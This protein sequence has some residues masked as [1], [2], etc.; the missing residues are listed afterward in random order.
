[1]STSP[2][3]FDLR[4]LLNGRPDTAV[5]RI[6]EHV[7]P[8]FARVLKIIG[9]DID[10]AH[11]Q[12]AYLYD[13]QGQRYIDCL[14]GY[15]VFNVGRNHPVIR[16]AIHQAM[17]MDL[18]NLVKMGAP[19][20]SGLLAE[21]LVKLA[22]GD[23]DTVF[24][25]NSGGEGIDTAIKYARAATGRPR[26]LHCKKAFHGLTLGAL[27]V[28][29]N[30]EFR[31]GFGPLDSHTTCVPFNDLPAL[32]R[33]LERGD[34]AGVIVEPIQGKGVFMPDDDY[35]P[36]LAAL[37]R[38]HEALFI[39]DEVQTGY[40]RT[41][42]MFAIEHWQVEPD[43]LVTAKALSGGYVPVGAVMSK[44]W[45]HQK[46]FSTLDRCVVHSTTFGQNDLAM[47]VGLATLHVLREEHIVENAA[48]VG[49]YLQQRLAGLIEKYDMVKDVRGKGLMLAIE[50]G[51]PRNLML[52]AGWKM[53]HSVDQSLFPQAIII[54]LMA[55]HHILTQVAGHHLDVIK[56]IPPLVLSQTD[57]DE[58]VEAFDMV[59]A[60]C[61]KFPGPAWEVGKRLTKQAMK[62]QPEKKAEPQAV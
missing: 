37:C 60:A 36:E 34:V 4:A 52:K 39:A 49:G 3:S 10:W 62:K 31:D 28:N 35:L 23:L 57:A 55:D 13:Q 53:M 7:N 43:I 12:G 59:T 56:L 29:G 40:G 61:H 1:M 24:F 44:R 21:Q 25:T 6:H 18:P 33:E 42:K 9:F 16:D 8:A 47:A 58:I 11:G 14:G 48:T 46:V 15:A 30:D 51:P 38:K 26:I 41:G 17:E 20:L 32:Q 5:D 22:P 50:Y 27:A 19:T 45:I 54:P 2:T